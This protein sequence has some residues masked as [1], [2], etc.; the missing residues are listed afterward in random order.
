MLRI[1]WLSAIACLCVAA[2]PGAAAPGDPGGGVMMA[3]ARKKPPAVDRI[4]AI[5]IEGAQRIEPETILSYVLIQS[6]DA[7]DGQKIEGS[8][9]ALLA[10]GLFADAALSRDGDILV[11]RVAENPVIN[12]V[13]FTGN[14]AIENTALAG[15]LQ[16]RP[17]V[18]YTR[19][20]VENDV[21]RLLDLYRRH[22][23]FGAAIEP[24]IISLP[25]NRVDVVFDIAEG[26]FTGIESIRF[27]GNLHY[28]AN[29]LRTVIR[30]KE[31]RWY[32]TPRSY[33]PDVLADDREL[34]RDFYLNAGYVD[35]RVVSGAAE[36]TPARDNINI[37]FTVEEGE[38]YRF[39]KIGT[40]LKLKDLSAAAVQPLLT[41]HSGEWYNAALVEKSIRTL[42]YTLHD[43]GYAFVEVAPEFV[44]NP[45]DHT[46]DVSFSAGEGPRVYVER[47]DIVGNVR[48]LDKVIRRQ[49][50]LVEGDAFT[51]SRLAQ[52]ERAIKKLSLFKKVDIAASPGSAPNRAIVTAEVEEQP[53][54]ELTVGPHFEIGEGLL[55]TVGLLERNFLGRAETATAKVDFSAKGTKTELSLADPDIAGRNI[56]GKWGFE[57]TTGSAHDW[58][59]LVAGFKLT[60]WVGVLV[61]RMPLSLL[62][63]LQGA[64][65][66]SLWS[67]DQG[68]CRRQF[69]RT[70]TAF[71]ATILLQ[72]TYAIIANVVRLANAGILSA[73]DV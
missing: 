33:D 35:F 65:Y 51:A 36:L 37:T 10:T 71:K 40:A 39:G 27:A 42:T 59:T 19:T 20:R 5:R 56:R 15:E 22:G 25:E 26:E 68:R 50:W 3:A 58:T 18:V 48:T 4:R 49:F 30:T 69:Q 41:I 13:A 57:F 46:V 8:Q 45:A 12:S 73:I 60:L 67:H 2:S 61:F 47:I 6:G 21:K 64:Y 62:L 63:L 34:L 70:M 53:T 11:V 43:R 72:F 1:L 14:S 66:T 28:D 7:W 17:R 16:L 9:K 24:K 31:S 54:G 23:R 32:R 38:R 44:R 55:A 29:V 52:S